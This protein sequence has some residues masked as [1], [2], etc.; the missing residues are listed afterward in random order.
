MPRLAAVAAD[1][2]APGLFQAHAGEAPTNSLVSRPR[3]APLTASGAVKECEDATQSHHL[4]APGDQEST[5]HS[6][7]YE[8]L[9]GEC[10]MMNL[11]VA[12]RISSLEAEFSR[13]ESWM[14]ST[15]QTHQD[16]VDMMLQRMF[17][18]QL[19]DMSK[20]LQQTRRL[21]SLVSD[22]D[23]ENADGDDEF[24]SLSS[25][26]MVERQIP[27]DAD[28]VDYE[29]PASPTKEES[30]P[31]GTH[32]SKEERTSN[33]LFQMADHH[34][35]FEYPREEPEAQVLEVAPLCRPCVDA[36]M[37]SIPASWK[38][39]I[40]EALES[41]QQ[42]SEVDARNSFIRLRQERLVEDEY[43][44]WYLTERGPCLSR[45]VRS[46]AFEIVSGAVIAL[47][48]AFMGLQ[49]EL[50]MRRQVERLAGQKELPYNWRPVD[51]GFCIIMTVELLLRII[52]LKCGFCFGNDC[53]WNL[54]DFIV[55]T[56]SIW[57]YLSS[58]DST[59]VSSA[60][61]VLRMMRLIRVLSALRKVPCL[62]KLEHML[63]A[64]LN[65]IPTLVPAMLMLV[66]LM[67]VF[68][69]FFMQG[70]TNYLVEVDQSNLDSDAEVLL[71]SFGSVHYALETLFLSA[72]GGRNWDGLLK[73][74]RRVGWIYEVTFPLYVGF[75]TFA[76]LNIL[77]GIFVDAAQ[78]FSSMDRE[79]VVELQVDKEEEYVK[80]LLNLFVEA[81]TDK[82][83]T[84]TWDEFMR[85]FEDPEVRAYL[86]G[87]DL[88]VTSAKKIFNLIDSEG[89]GEIAIQPFLETCLQLRGQAQ[90]VDIVIMR[91]DLELM[92]MGKLEEM[93]KAIGT[94]GNNVRMTSQVMKHSMKQRKVERSLPVSRERSLKADKHMDKE[95]SFSSSA[96]SPML[97]MRSNIAAHG[98]RSSMRGSLVSQKASWA[99]EASLMSGVLSTSAPVSQ[100]STAGSSWA[101]RAPQSVQGST[102]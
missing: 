32:E 77:T 87:M 43:R 2:P 70:L 74:L 8:L 71:D 1:S 94:I 85:H 38:S 24:C 98:T 13:H 31:A 91:T 72:V 46:T 66:L 63:V 80:G 75:V 9:R 12:D 54:F 26:T 100:K 56:G 53:V 47:N 88:N 59:S 65:T 101:Y 57:H 68:V 3:E 19:A 102:G 20:L 11:M 60:F 25:M 62:R 52:G 86:K 76:V 45:M 22:P 42:Q 30:G 73:S 18:T 10:G 96:M 97:S 4:Q 17:S 83:G 33:I 95:W 81:D 51:M 40:T 99:Q 39:R 7:M 79:L 21:G 16:S 41:P 50:D 15:L 44:Q 69:V 27:E 64:L 28:I 55:V 84:L 23:S 82:S 48:A 90:V 35:A 92:L 37:A 93:Q 58:N 6:S 29:K 36:L 49:V 34:E 5:A 61:R 78:Q 89:K 67:F 14:T